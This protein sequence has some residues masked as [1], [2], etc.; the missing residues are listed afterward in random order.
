[1]QAHEPTRSQPPLLTFTERVFSS[2]PRIDQRQW[3]QAY[4]TGLLRTEGKKSVRRLAAAV[5]DSP[6]ASQS[7]HQFVNASPWEWGPPRGE[8]MRWAEQRLDPKAWILDVAVLRKRGDHSCGVHRR[9]VPASGRSVNCQVGIGAF[10]ATQSDAVPVDWRLL[11]PGAWLKDEHRRMRARI[12]VDVLPRTIEQ[13]ALDLV[14]ALTESTSLSPCPL[15]AD[16]SAYAGVVG[17]VRGLSASGCNFVVAV[18]GRMRVVPG[19]ASSAQSA[20]TRN[21]PAAMDAQRF[22]E[23]KHNSHLRLDTVAVGDGRLGNTSLTTGLVRLPDS[24]FARQMPSP[25]YRL[26]A[27]RH[28]AGRRSDR[29]WLTNMLNGRAEQL[30]ALTRLQQRARRTVQTLEHDFGLLDFEGRSFP[31]WHHHMTLVSAAHAYSQLRATMPVEPTR[32]YQVA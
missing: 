8:L 17:L 2:L 13:H 6:T 30:L 11:L 19:G 20:Y 16:L 32:A 22:F 5:S 15:V 31:G 26:F 29:I 10:L 14:D 28:M 24:S 12:P 3:A 1:M 18:P 9:F 23:L 4:L 21:L 25:T 7:M 27:L